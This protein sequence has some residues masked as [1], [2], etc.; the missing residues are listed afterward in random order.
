MVTNHKSIDPGFKFP[1]TF[2]ESRDRV[3]W[4]NEAGAGEIEF[5]KAFRHRVYP[6]TERDGSCWLCD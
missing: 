1:G 2:Y 3:E 6:S 5:Q 4:L